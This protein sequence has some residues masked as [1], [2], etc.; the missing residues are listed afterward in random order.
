MFKIVSLLPSATEIIAALGFHRELVGRSH[1]CDFPAWVKSLPVLTEPHLKLEGSSGEIDRQVKNLL[2]QGLSIYRVDV[3]KLQELEPDV[4]VTQSQCE[5]CAVS[6]AELQQALAD[7]VG[8]RA[9]IVS[10][11]PDSLTDVWQDILRV[12]ERLGVKERGLHLVEKLKFSMEQI[13]SQIP[14]LERS[15]SV[16]CIEWLDPLMAAGNW[17]PELVEMAGGKNLFGEKGRHS[18]WLSWEELK[19]K[20]PDILVIL[21]CGFDISRSRRERSL[22][23]TQAIWKDLSAVRNQR[24]YLTDGN[25]YFNRP[26][27][28]LLESLEILAEIFHPEIFHFGHQGRAWQHLIPH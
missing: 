4:I 27:P 28:R 10:L 18:P 23:E 16:A 12:A 24:V 5:V 3:Q 13:A 6:E 19:E 20:D 25:Q 9:E 21:P 14:A 15:P 17:M 1:E 22:L 26:G 7:W 11:K 8:H 2:E